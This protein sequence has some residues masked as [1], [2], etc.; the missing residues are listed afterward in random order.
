MLRPATEH[1]VETIRTWRNHPEVRRNFLYRAE[2][3]AAHHRQW[4]DRV[5]ADPAERVLMYEHAGSA[6][7]VVTINDHD[8]VERRAEWGFFLDVDGLR[9]RGTL[10]AAWIGLERA[11]VRYAFD[12]LR[13]SVLGGRTL[14]DNRA[15]LELHRR[16]GFVTVPERCYTAMVDGRECRVVWMER[17]AERAPAGQ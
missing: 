11:A 9:S 7:G 3:T 12:E 14:A 15:V 5:S 17:L 13:L 10:S 8:P 16:T 1:D 4:W 2:I 6:C